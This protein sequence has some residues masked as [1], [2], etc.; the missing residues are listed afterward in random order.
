[1][2]PTELGTTEV[3]AILLEQQIRGLAIARGLAEQA[4]RSREADPAPVGWQGV[5]RSAYDGLVRGLDSEL[6]RGARSLEEAATQ[7]GRALATLG[8]RVG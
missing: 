2:E 4:I 6:R 3:L 7:T 5:A 1:M 8:R